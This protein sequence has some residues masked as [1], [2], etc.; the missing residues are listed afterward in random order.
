MDRVRLTFA[1]IH[2]NLAQI[3]PMEIAFLSSHPGFPFC[4]TNSNLTQPVIG[5]CVEYRDK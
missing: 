4:H 5:S 3:A 2:R 1:Y